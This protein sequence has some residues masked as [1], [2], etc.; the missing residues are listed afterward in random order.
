MR[1]NPPPMPTKPR[2]AAAPR[3]NRSPARDARPNRGGPGGKSRPDGAR[4]RP[5]RTDERNPGRGGGNRSGGTQGRGAGP[6]DRRDGP[7]G[8]AGPQ[9]RRDGPA[10]GAGPAGGAGSKARHDGPARGGSKASSYGPRGAAAERD[11]D[12]PRGAGAQDRRGAAADGPRGSQARRGASPRGPGSQDRRGGPRG[13]DSKDRRGA[14]GGP[15]G[16]GSKDRRDAPR[17]AGA[18]SPTRTA[19]SKD[20]PNAADRTPGVTPAVRGWSTGGAK[21]T[22]KR[23]PAGDAKPA[24][25]PRAKAGAKPDPHQASKQRL[26]K[27]LAAAGVA[28]RRKA[29]DLISAGRVRVNGKV[30]TEL[31][32]R[33]D[34]DRDQVQVDGK[35]VQVEKKVYFVLNKPDGVVCS[36]E[37]VKDAEGRPT[38]L[39]LFPDLPQ[40]IYPIGRLDFHTRGLLI[41]TNDGELAAAL[42]HPRHEVTKTYHVKF[43]G[44]LDEEDLGRLG[45]PITLEDGT[46]TR[47]AEEISVIKDTDT[48]TWVQVTLRQG[49]NRQIRRMGDAI[50]RPVL[51]LIRVAVAGLT[52]D[53]LADGEFRPLT[54]TEV[55]DLMAAANP[56]KV[57]ASPR[58]PKKAAKAAGDAGAAKPAAT[59]RKPTNARSKGSASA[60]K[61]A[62]SAAR[63][64]GDRPKAR[65]NP[66]SRAPG[67]KPAGDSRPAARSNR[68]LAQRRRP[69]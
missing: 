44:R 66:G 2:P 57:A 55:Y 46:V 64:T 32:S 51:K 5:A 38:V 56:E 24:S 54:P 36:A 62:R 48:N 40:R 1:D 18:R 42:T 35:H 41:L 53:G 13:P 14:A 4:S 65:P 27:V 22:S 7:A 59:P 61:P 28:A 69:G 25:K 39:S 12:T 11:S 21:S 15:R 60:P 9:D 34:P 6:K 16:A 49:L 50:G 52:A 10:R 47:A 20:R 30:V 26:Q 43:Q 3:P 23:A 29:E 31:G 37:G 33:V 19:A 58:K 45:Q 68:P 67:R 17:G 8:G 63:P